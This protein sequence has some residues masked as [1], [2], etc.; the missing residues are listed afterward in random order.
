MKFITWPSFQ[1]HSSCPVSPYR[2]L[3]AWP[4]Q[5]E[6]SVAATTSQLHLATARLATTAHRERRH[7]RRMSARWATTAQRAPQALYCAPVAFTRM[8]CGSGRA[9]CALLAIT[10][11]TA[12]AWWLSMIPSLA[13]WDITALRVCIESSFAAF[14]R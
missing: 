7:P 13:Q 3:T 5:E 1:L 12:W 10:A 11:T 9:R 6:S 4:A 14:N 8:S 2:C